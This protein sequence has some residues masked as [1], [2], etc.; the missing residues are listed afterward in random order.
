[1]EISDVTGGEVYAV[2]WRLWRGLCF[3]CLG[4]LA[5]AERLLGGIASIDAAM[6]V[7]SSMRR[8]A[9]SWIHA[10]RGALDDA[11]ALAAELAEHGHAHH[12]RLEES[13]G[14]WALGEVLRRTGDLDAADRE[15][16]AALTMAVPLEQPG[17]LASLAR[18]RLAQGR[19]AEAREAAE[20]AF[21]TAEAIGGYG[22]FRGA[23]LRLTRAEALHATG[24]LDAARAAI[25]DARARLLAIA[26]TIEDPAYRRSFLEAVPENARTL[27]LAG[28]WLGEPAPIA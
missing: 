21:A 6:G 26:G 12:N 17:V 3:W 20:D 4:A 22:M 7:A 2:C 23:F 14:C 16:A 28:D 15:L 10:D 11:R 5:D 1:V 24:A 25:A 27:A 8:F 13:R 9:L 18:L 19:A